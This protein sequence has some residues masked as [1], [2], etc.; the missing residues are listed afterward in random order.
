MVYSILTIRSVMVSDNNTF[1]CE[2]QDDN[3]FSSR[4]DH[5]IQINGNVLIT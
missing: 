4:D 2:A 3:G 5:A 1:V